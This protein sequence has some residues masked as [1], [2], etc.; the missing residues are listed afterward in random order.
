LCVDPP[1]NFAD[2]LVDQA[3]VD[4]GMLD[5][6]KDGCISDAEMTDELKEQVVSFKKGAAGE[7]GYYW[8]EKQVQDGLKALTKEMDARASDIDKDKNGCVD[9][10]EYKKIQKAHNDCNAQFVMMDTNGDGK[11][12]RQEAANF[13]SHHMDHADISYGKQRAIFEALTRIR[14]ISCKRRNS[15]RQEKHSRVMVMANS[16]VSSALEMSSSFLV[17][18]HHRTL[19]GYI[20]TLLVLDLY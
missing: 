5:T 1:D 12:S 6:N 2:E 7:R 8:Q 13:V 11:V 14:I 4:F 17:Q 10:D 9:E 16:E 20:L 3:N 18:P 19:K 15:V